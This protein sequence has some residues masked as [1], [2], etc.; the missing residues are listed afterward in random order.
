MGRAIILVLDS[1]GI[2]ATDDCLALL[3]ER[4]SG[5]VAVYPDAEREDYVDRHSDGTPNAITP[6]EFARHAVRWADQGVQVIGGCCGFGVDYVH[7][8]SRALRGG[9]R[10]P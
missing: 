2:G 1:V 7:A 9:K 5:P 6:D 4:W 3:R 8:A 10:N